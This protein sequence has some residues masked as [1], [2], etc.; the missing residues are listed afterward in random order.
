MN[1]RGKNTYELTPKELRIL[2]GLNTPRKVQDFLDRLPINHELQGE[3][4]RS[5]RRVLRDRTAHCFEGA[6]LASAAFLVNGGKALL[7]DLKTDADA[8]DIDHV[9]ALFRRRGLWGAVSKTN[10]VAL[11]Y[12]EPVYRTVREL[13]MSY[14]HE[15]FM[16]NGKKTLRSYSHVFDL[17]PL[18]KAG[19]L[20]LEEELHDLVDRLDESPHVHILP[21]G[22]ERELRRADP[23]E[24]AS[25]KLEEWSRKGKKLH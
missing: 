15:Y 5:P 7:L 3:T 21:K 18:L 2:R 11:R 17:G 23:I 16:D 12:R 9:V 13:A 1:P 20:T 6:L 19:W 4:Y 24:R 10:H 22:A 8:P 14:F 25:G